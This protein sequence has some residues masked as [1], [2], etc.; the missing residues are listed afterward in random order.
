MEPLP[1]YITHSKLTKDL[2]SSRLQLSELQ[3]AHTMILIALRK[4]FLNVLNE[5]FDELRTAYEECVTQRAEWFILDIEESNEKIIFMVRF[6]IKETC[7]IISEHTNRELMNLYLSLAIEAE[8][9]FLA[10]GDIFV[11]RPIAA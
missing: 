11:I 1:T 8:K 5:I 7:S 2:A 6:S 3:Y 9:R 10:L 4:E